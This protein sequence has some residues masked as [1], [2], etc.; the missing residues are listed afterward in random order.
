M[1]AELVSVASLFVMFVVMYCVIRMY[2]SVMKLCERK[3]FQ[4]QDPEIERLLQTADRR[5][6]RWSLALRGNR[7]TAVEQGAWVNRAR[8]QEH[9]E[10]FL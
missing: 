2:L 9:D 8:P 10:R 3:V 7:Q 4:A 1:T 5:A 6:A